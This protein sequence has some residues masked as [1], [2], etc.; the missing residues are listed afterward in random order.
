MVKEIQLTQG[1]VALVDDED[2][3]LVSSY[4]WHA[5]KNRSGIW[6]AYTCMG[7]R[8]TAMHQL[9]TAFV[10]T[11]HVDRDGLN[12]Q[13]RNLRLCTTSQNG[14]NRGK[15]KNNRSGF[16]GVCW[17]RTDH[18]WIAYIQCQRKWKYLGSYDVPLHAAQVY[19][20]AALALFGEFANLNDIEKV[21]AQLG[22]ATFGCA[23]D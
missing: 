17:N 2:Y 1:K 18:K 20:I 13:R 19:N 10:Q 23:S 8:Q 12:N 5:G 4:K 9:L 14:A 6:Y 7:N 15:Q 11:D 16:K 22:Q 3:D 21:S